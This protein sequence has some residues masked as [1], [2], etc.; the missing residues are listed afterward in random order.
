MLCSMLFMTS[1]EGGDSGTAPKNVA[2][3]TMKISVYTISF[4]SNTSATIMYNYTDGPQRISYSSITYKKTGSY[5]AT[6]QITG[7]PN[8]KWGG[9]DYMDENFSLIFTS[10]NQG[11]YNNYDTFTIF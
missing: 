3:K 6:L 4:T 7:M 11:T 2:G 8:H 9:G 1:C 5:S 10:P